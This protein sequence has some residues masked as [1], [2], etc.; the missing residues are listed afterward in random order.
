VGKIRRK[1]GRVIGKMDSVY[2]HYLLL[3]SHLW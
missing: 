2:N 1:G 3:V